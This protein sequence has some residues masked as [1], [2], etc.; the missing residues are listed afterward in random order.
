LIFA[1]LLSGA[2]RAQQLARLHVQSITLSASAP[3]PQVDT[4]FDVTLT[5]R[6]RENPAGP[7]DNV[8]LPTFAGADE[9][10]DE[11]V[12]SHG[13][14]GSVYRETLRLVAHSTGPLVI[15]SAYLDAI[16]ARD[17]KAKRFISNELHLN[18]GGAPFD[19]WRPLRALALGFLEIVLLLTA[20]FVVVTIFRRKRREPVPAPAQAAPPVPVPP[21]V[22]R[23]DAE[24]ERL[25]ARRDRAA[26]LRVREALWASLGALQGE[27]LGDALR[28]AAVGDEPTRRMLVAAE[29]AAFVEDE[30]LPQAV[31]DLLEER[32]GRFA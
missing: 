21:P 23:L 13:A 25:R 2:A 1:A 19:V 9:L 31:E 3:Q 11:R 15:G 27:T 17:G 14:G 28:R 12:F 29:R 18:V 6:V 32:E 20:L 8:V 10:G 26:V 5:I 16:D 24:F 7:L 22:D 4:P 30:R